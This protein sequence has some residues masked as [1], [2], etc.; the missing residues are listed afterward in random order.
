MEKEIIAIIA[1]ALFGLLSSLLKKLR[2]E[3]EPDES[4]LQRKPP[5]RDVAANDPFDD[6]E[7]DLS[8]WDMLFGFLRA[9]TRTRAKIALQNFERCRAKRPGFRSRYRA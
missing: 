5:S 3:R 1:F 6:K 7:I 9:R 8:E 2:G 4:K